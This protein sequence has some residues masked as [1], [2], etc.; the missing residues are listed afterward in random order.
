M[1]NKSKLILLIVAGVIL[2]INSCTKDST[3]NPTVTDNRD[4][5]VGTYTDVETRGSTNQTFN[6]VVSKSNADNTKILVSNF[7]LAGSNVFTS[8]TV[9]S[10]TSLTIPSQVVSGSTL[11]GSGTVN[12][13]KINFTYTDNDGITTTNVTAVCTKQ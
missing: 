3:S 2:T 5:L 7:N 12:G 6:I 11:A 9:N 13:N 8:M 4:A 10:S 1:K